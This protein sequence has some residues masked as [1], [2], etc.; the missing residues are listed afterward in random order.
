MRLVWLVCVAVIFS[1][2]SSIVWGKTDT[3]R[4]QLNCMQFD[5]TT[6]TEPKA[7]IDKSPAQPSESSLPSDEEL[8]QLEALRQWSL[9][10]DP[11]FDSDC[12]YSAWAALA[13]RDDSPCVP[14]SGCAPQDSHSI[15]EFGT[16]SIRAKYTDIHFRDNK[17][18]TDEIPMRV[19]YSLKA[20]LF[21]GGCQ[22][23]ANSYGQLS[24]QYFNCLI[25]NAS[26][27][28]GSK[29]HWLVPDETF[30]GFTGQFD[31]YAVTRPSDPVINRVLNP[32]LFNMWQRV[33]TNRFYQDTIILGLEHRSTGQVVEQTEDNGA[34]MI[35]ADEL[36]EAIDE[37]NN[38]AF[39]TLSQGAEYISASY[40]RQIERGQ[41]PLPGTFEVQLN[42]KFYIS[43]EKGE[44][45]WMDENHGFDDYDIANVVTSWI[46]PSG[47]SRLDLSVRGGNA[48]FDGFSY[49][50]NLSFT[51]CLIGLQLPLSFAFH[52][53]PMD[54]LSYYAVPTTSYSIGYDF[55]STRRSYNCGK[56]FIYITI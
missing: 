1:A 41:L 39:D 47:Y 5:Q 49:D 31:F 54:T 43:E 10:N 56:K 33:H 14:W 50:T 18:I 24:R 16:T 3:T 38:E 36:N 26:E 13:A 22:R 2:I 55:S 40:T 7:K 29:E 53:G 6:E 19:D 21:R 34:P 9:M 32:G 27:A 8:Q 12:Y 23:V 25:K 15:L 51:S 37:G 44:T 17:T 30:L 42:T 48:G 4:H 35:S 45:T 11:D 28:G 46:S 20:V 52:N